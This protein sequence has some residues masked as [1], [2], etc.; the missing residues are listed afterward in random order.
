VGNAVI[1]VAA[2]KGERAGGD[3]PKQWRDLAGKSAVDWCLQTFRGHPD[4]DQI[5]LVVN[6]DDFEKTKGFAG[7]N[8]ITG[9]A[10]RMASVLNGLNA[11][12]ENPPEKVLIHDVARPGVTPEIID[13]VLGALK[14]SC[15]AAPA[16]AVSDALWRGKDAKVI[17]TTDR[18]GLYRAQTPQGFRYRSILQAHKNFTGDAADDVEVALA[19]GI[20]VKIVPGDESNFKITLPADFARAENF[21]RGPMDIRTGNGFDVHAFEP[22]NQVTLCGVDIAHD[23][24]LKGH[25]DAD[26]AM[27]AVTDALYGALGQGDIG[28]WFPPSDPQW[29]GSESDVFLRHACNLMVKEGFH[30]T[31][32]DCTI[33]CEEPKIGPHSTAM[34]QKMAGIM[35]LSAD[36]VSIKA[37]TSESLG[38]TGRKEGIAAMATATLV[39]S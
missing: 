25:S 14:T 29:E 38:F 6:S 23:K 26:V 8:V 21:L 39:K 16:L 4:I 5:V 30:L 2:G 27:H 32:V 34:R 9:G 3:A 28:Q 11:L 37:T 31:H 13:G 18:T 7:I 15:A 10:N 33:I 17:D 20:D 35:G 12:G 22:G 24:S 1:L 36:R 19:A